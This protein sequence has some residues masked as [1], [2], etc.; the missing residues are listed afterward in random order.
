VT[1]PDLSSSGAGSRALEIGTAVA[2][3]AVF[4]GFVG[5]VFF[6]H[7]VFTVR[8][9]TIDDQR[10]RVYGEELASEITFAVSQRV[11][12]TRAL[13][14]VV[15][16]DPDFARQ[17]FDA[18][19]DGLV[20]DL[21]GVL[22]LQ[23][24]PN[25]VVS[26]VT[27]PDR[28]RNVVG[29]DLFASANDSAA[30][31]AAVSTRRTVIQGPFELAQ[32]GTGV[33]ARYPIFISDL[34][35]HVDA[36]TFWGFSTVVFDLDEVVA[37]A[38]REFIPEDIAFSVGRG[39]ALARPDSSSGR[40]P[41]MR[42][43]VSVPLIVDVAEPWY[44]SV[45]RS[46][47][48]PAELLF[49]RPW[50][51]TVGLV[52]ALL[53]SWVTYRIRSFQRTLQA[54]VLLSTGKLN[55]ALIRAEAA[56]QSAAKANTAKSDFLRQMSHEFRTPLNAVIGYSGVLLE[57]SEAR[58]TTEQK[59]WLSHIEASGRHLLSLVNRLL[60]LTKIEHG[61][62]DEVIEPILVSPI[63]AESIDL[64]RPGAASRSLR[65]ENTIPAPSDV[66][67]LA[68]STL[69]RQV[70]LNLLSNAV[71]YNREG[72][73]IRVEG[74][75]TP[76]GHFRVTVE[77]SGP[78]LSLEDQR[79]V[80][81]PFNRAHQEDGDP[82]V[83]SVGLGLFITQDLV[84]RVGGELGVTSELGHGSTFWFELPLAGV[85]SGEGSRRSGATSEA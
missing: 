72:G 11:G 12:L 5:A 35:E 1:R 81:E 68:S 85:D 57:D 80:F 32:G 59:R 2:V 56:R 45:A 47:E 9:K 77:D 62:D 46:G 65:I 70:M 61:L 41:R 49:W 19:A 54:E 8:T 73:S 15:R 18:I 14:A 76:L 26:Y 52:V 28:N 17:R 13:A 64:V 44:I 38:R 42:G 66:Q 22:S 30:A 79:L 36:S 37:S 29:L 48:L 75:T 10:L 4:A 25:G 82:D 31:R 43:G 7:T 63:V 6:L 83:D 71:K 20:A 84:R 33:V 67:V 69:L 40:S 60:D 21:S 78:G 3:F 50:L 23:L 74:Q 34:S 53:V 51:W 58:I 39:V 27:S 24:A 16:T 55:R